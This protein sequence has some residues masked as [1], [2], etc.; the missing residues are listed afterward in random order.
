MARTVLVL[1]GGGALGAYQAGS[2]LALSEAG[3]LPDAI[4]GCS[5]GALNAAF[6]A[7]DPG[8]ARARALVDWWTDAR[9]RTLLAPGWRTRV[10]GLVRSGGAA[11][12]DAAALRG[13]VASEVPCHD[14]SELAVPVT[15][16][17]TCL[18]CC[19]SVAHRTGPVADILAASCSLPGLLPPVLL[20]DGHLHVDGGVTDGVPLAAAL[21]QAGPDDDVLVLD[22]GLAPVT[23]LSDCAAGPQ[24]GRA[25][26]GLPCAEP[27]SYIPPVERSRGAVDV[28]LR[29]FTAA[30]AA[31]SEGATRPGLTD[32]RVHVLPHVAD[33][34]SA[35]LLPQLPRGPRDL[36]RAGSLV[37]AGHRAAAAWLRTAVLR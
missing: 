3:V 16:V 37:D 6:L 25:G 35:G 22:C 34:W 19:A 28:V 17:T 33:A 32:P 21:A 24:P 31:A 11:L 15:A 12:L 18:D 23:R 30:R 5:A 10:S 4:V 14:L 26:C 27:R 13:F 7:S 2:L 8:T 36:S 29:S 1:G 20:P 9:S